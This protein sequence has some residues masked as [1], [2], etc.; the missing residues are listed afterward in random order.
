MDCFVASA[1]RNDTGKQLYSMGL[2]GA[3][4]SDASPDDALHHLEKDEA[5][6]PENAP[7]LSYFIICPRSSPPGLAAVW[8]LAYHLPASRSAIWLSVNVA[9]P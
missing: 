9:V 3:S 4:R 8:T 5:T 6:E 1:P 2:E 7:T